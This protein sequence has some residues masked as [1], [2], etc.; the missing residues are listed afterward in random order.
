MTGGW[1]VL[2]EH[3]CS[4]GLSHG[5][6]TPC[7][8][9]L[10]ESTSV[11]SSDSQP[12]LAS[13]PESYISLVTT[14]RYKQT[15]TKGLPKSKVKEENQMSGEM[16]SGEVGSSRDGRRMERVVKCRGVSSHVA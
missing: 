2:V 8:L 1:T 15:G 9:S 14:S 5:A 3:L 13:D 7:H 6:S 12:C 4:S 16:L 10:W 11:E